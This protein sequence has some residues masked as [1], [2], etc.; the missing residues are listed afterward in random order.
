MLQ[1]LCPCC[2]WLCCALS[3]ALMLQ[4]LCHCCVWLCC[5]PC[6]ACCCAHVVQFLIFIG[7][8]PTASDVS[9]HGSGVQ[10]TG[11]NFFFSRTNPA[12]PEIRWVARNY[13]YPVTRIPTGVVTWE[14]R[15]AR[16]HIN[17]M[18][19]VHE[20][21]QLPYKTRVRKNGTPLRRVYEC[22]WDYNRSPRQRE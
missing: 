20:S 2:V 5:V 4:L 6:A 17:P 11:T 8:P 1:L 9:I 3:Y 19:R 7:F 10:A 22:H 15:G 13:V 16:A 14:A 12:T 18:R 21:A